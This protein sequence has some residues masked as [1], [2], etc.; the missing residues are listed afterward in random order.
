MQFTFDRKIDHRVMDPDGSQTIK[1]RCGHT[2][3]MVI[4]LPD[5]VRVIPCAQCVDDFVTSIR[6]VDESKGVV[7]Q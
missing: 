7:K 1:L 5:R 3:C 2:V 4:P 6:T